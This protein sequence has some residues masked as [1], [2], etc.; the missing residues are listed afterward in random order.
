MFW[1]LFKRSE[2]TAAYREQ[3]QLNYVASKSI[4]KVADYLA[5]DG[6]RLT[7]PAQQVIIDR[8]NTQLI[9]AMLLC[10]KTDFTDNTLFSIIDRDVKSEI[11]R[12]FD[13][14]AFTNPPRTA[15]YLPKF[16]LRLAENTD[17]ITLLTRCANELH[18]FK[19]PKDEFEKE[20]IKSLS[21]EKLLAYLEENDLCEKAEIY[22]I[23]FSGDFLFKELLE[24][25]YVCCY[26]SAEKSLVEMVDDNELRC[27]LETLQKGKYNLCVEATEIL[28]AEHPDVVKEYIEQF[29]LLGTAQKL[30]IE[31]FP[32]LVEE[33]VKHHGF[34]GDE[35]QIAYVKQASSEQ[36]IAYVHK[37]GLVDKAEIELL[38]RGNNEEIFAYIAERQLHK[39]AEAEMLKKDDTELLSEYLTKYRLHDGNEI[40]L[41]EYVKDHGFL[42]IYLRYQMLSAK[43][44]AYLRKLLE[45]LTNKHDSLVESMEDSLQKRLQN[46][47]IS[48]DVFN[49]YAINHFWQLKEFY[50][51]HQN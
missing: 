35:A 26:K 39:N 15:A 23:R 24:S 41:M 16:A 44:D 21:V 14:M 47:S 2:D 46:V 29:K 13:V 20:L 30:F 50:N 33:Y 36:L 27:Y 6:V 34:K 17:N 8:G 25:G 7:P 12:A 45:H 9:E 38:K 22:L 4:S 37:Y 48:R 40:V 10:I 32:Q 5:Q 18:K 49:A 1:N 42:K 19:Q 51:S 31:Q 11:L 28:L 43:G 3:K